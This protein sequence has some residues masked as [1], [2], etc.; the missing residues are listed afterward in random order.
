MPPTWLGRAPLPLLGISWNLSTAVPRDG[1]LL[2]LLLPPAAPLP[3]AS[4][5]PE[6][7][8]LVGRGG[9]PSG[10]ACDAGRLVGR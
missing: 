9:R 6:P 5:P 2:D 8:R 1:P 3:A 4:R 10:C 7:W